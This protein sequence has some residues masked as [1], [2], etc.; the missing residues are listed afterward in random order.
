MRRLV[1]L[2]ALFFMAPLA[3]GQATKD[4]ISAYSAKLSSLTSLY[5]TYTFRIVDEK[6]DVN[7]ST[8]GEFYSQGDMFLVKTA[9]SD[10][11][12]DGESKHIYDKGSEEVVIIG[13]NRSDTNMS[14]NPFAVLKSGETKY[15]YPPAPKEGH[16]NGK[17]CY[18]V[19]LTPL[20]TKSDHTSVEI[21]VAKSDYSIVRIRYRTAKGE[22]YQADVKSISEGGERDK[23]FFMIDLDSMEGVYVTDLR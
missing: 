3:Y 4:V 21:V 19:T 14:E 7:F 23:S 13:H 22:T 2:I 9:Y 10:I 15:S 6:G 18:L 12:C 20:D 5:A 11:Y 1:I 16:L 8:D 17:D